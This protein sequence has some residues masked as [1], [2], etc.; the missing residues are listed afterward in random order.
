VL[1]HLKSGTF[2]HRE[3]MRIRRTV[4]T[5]DIVFRDKN[6]LTYATTRQYYVKWMIRHNLYEC[7]ICKMS[8]WQDK[9]IVLQIDHI[10]GDNQ[11]NSLMNLRLLCPNCH[12][13]THTFGGANSSRIVN[14]D[15]FRTSRS[16]S[17]YYA[18]CKKELNDS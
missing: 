14:S 1:K 5:D 6:G 18:L 16:I 11:N 10:N 4:Y 8:T 17:N 2:E 9:F 3:L 15:E 12:S 7:S 13:Q